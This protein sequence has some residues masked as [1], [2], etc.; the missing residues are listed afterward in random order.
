M[1][2][3]NSYMFHVSMF[4]HQDAILGKSLQLRYT[5]QHANLDSTPPCR[6]EYKLTMLKCTKLMTIHYS[7]TISNI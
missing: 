1:T 6:N 5:S 4:Q 7:I 2:Y 3:I